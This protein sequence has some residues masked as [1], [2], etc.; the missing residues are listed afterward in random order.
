MTTHKECAYSFEA[1]N[2]NTACIT[3]LLASTDIDT[4]YIYGLRAKISASLRR[5]WEN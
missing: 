2:F 5:V 3:K 4:V 1:S